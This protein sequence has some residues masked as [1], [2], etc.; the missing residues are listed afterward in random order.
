MLHIHEKKVYSAVCFCLSAGSPVSLAHLS[1][2][3]VRQNLGPTNL[4]NSDLSALKLLPHVLMYLHS[5]LGGGL[6]RV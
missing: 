1:R 3:V 5:I 2:V 4:A 6:W